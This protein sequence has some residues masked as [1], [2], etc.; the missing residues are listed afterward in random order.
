MGVVFF[1]FAVSPLVP[2][3]ELGVG[4]GLAIVLDVTIVRGLL[5]PATVA[6]LGELNWWRPEWSSGRQPQPSVPE[7]REQFG[8][9]LDDGRGGGA[10]G[11]AAGE[12]AAAEERALERAVAVHAAAAEAGDLARGVQAG[13]GSPSASSTRAREVGLAGRRASCG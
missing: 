12:Q 1:S 6:L 4:M 9:Q 2:F 10:A 3:Q 13:S 11:D 8:G 7:P 5:V